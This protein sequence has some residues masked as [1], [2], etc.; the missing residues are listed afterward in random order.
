MKH[1]TFINFLLAVIISTAPFARSYAQKPAVERPPVKVEVVFTPDQS[2]DDLNK[3]KRDMAM[4]GISL[5]YENV[6]FNDA[7]ELSEIRFRVKDNKGN[8]GSASGELPSDIPFGFR[9]DQTEGA[10]KTVQVGG[11]VD[12]PK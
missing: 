2:M 3:L 10:S 1:R 6:K 4:K 9:I 5:M 11:L 8:T 12:E 7:G